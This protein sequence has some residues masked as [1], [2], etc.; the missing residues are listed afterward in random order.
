ME[1]LSI[2][3]AIQNQFSRDPLVVKVWT[4]GIFR[5]S[6]STMEDLERQIQ[7]TDFGILVLSPDD[8]ITSPDNNSVGPRDNVILELGLLIGRW[9]ASGPS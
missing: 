1:G 7:T 9:D 4:D 8:K 6:R 2:A 5:A 3:R